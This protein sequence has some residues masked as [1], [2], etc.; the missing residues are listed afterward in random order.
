LEGGKG[1][2]EGRKQNLEGAWRSGTLQGK[3]QQTQQV[4]S[5][6]GQLGGGFEKGIGGICTTGLFFSEIFD[7][8][9]LELRMKGYAESNI[10][11][12][13][14]NV[15]LFLRFTGISP[16]RAASKDLERY[17][18]TLHEPG[19]YSLSTIYGKIISLKIFYSFLHQ[20]GRILCDP[21][22][23]LEAPEV[24]RSIPKNVMSPGEMESI[25]KSISGTSL[26]KLRDKAIVEVLYSTGLRLSELTGLDIADIDLNAGILRVQKGKGGRDRQT[27]LN[28]SSVS[29][30]RTY[31]QRRK[32]T[33]DETNA[34]W[35]N[36]LGERL[37]GQ[38]IR[39]IL[40]RAAKKAEVTN[41]SHPHAWRHA[42]AT[43]LLR[44][45]ANIV[46]VQRFLGHVS[47]QS[48]QIYTHV[49]IQDLKEIHRRC[50]PRERDPIPAE[51]IPQLTPS[52]KEGRFR[53][54][55]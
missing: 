45:G 11:N 42:L 31:L 2:L 43:A 29:A 3:S 5:E 10:K 41:K 32:Q 33:P 53:Y 34:L 4:I 7:E 6:N 13:C 14:R 12:T 51:I 15:K 37:S 9:A 39:I 35:I 21:A 44:Q 27:V 25:L 16:R 28:P 55:S 46:E 24:K 54:R 36:Y 26:L 52:F 47:I 17:A 40:L 22:V 1:N 19:R 30:L 49:L 50:H 48:T 20:A 38:W 23:G 8:F 18:A